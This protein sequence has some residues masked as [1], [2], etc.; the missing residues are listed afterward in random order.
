LNRAFFVDL[1]RELPDALKALS[2][3]Q[4]PPGVILPFFLGLGLRNHLRLT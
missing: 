2:G 3:F 4:T 1:P